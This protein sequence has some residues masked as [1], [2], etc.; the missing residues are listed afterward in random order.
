[1]NANAAGDRQVH[2]RGGDQAAAGFLV[3]LGGQHAL[4][5]VLVG[6]E[7]GHVVSVDADRVRRRACSR[8]PSDEP[9][10]SPRGSSAV[11]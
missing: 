7:R 5:H 6:A 8:W 4:H 3:G 11:M 1:M 9:T 10:S 2:E